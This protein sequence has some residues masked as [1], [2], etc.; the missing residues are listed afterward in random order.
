MNVLKCLQYTDLI[1]YKTVTATS[2][3]RKV[4][5]KV[6][7][8]YVD[9]LSLFSLDSPDTVVVPLVDLRVVWAL[10]IA[11]AGMQYSTRGIARCRYQGL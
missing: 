5:F 4:Q 7:Y 9:F 10:Q 1:D 8:S 6:I 2:S 3:A 11:V